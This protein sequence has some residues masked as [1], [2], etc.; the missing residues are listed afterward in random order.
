MNLTIFNDTH[1][2][3]TRQTGTTLESQQKL[4]Q[5]MFKQFSEL[6]NKAS[7]GDLLINGDIF[8]KAEVNKATEF[9]TYTLLLDWCQK[10]PE[11]T[12]YLAAGNHDLSKNSESVSSFDN[13]VAYLQSSVR[14]LCAIREHAFEIYEGVYV[15]PH[16]PNQE[17]FNQELETVKA[18]KPLY[19]FLHA[20][21]DNHFAAQTDH[22]LNVSEE[23][24]YSFAQLGCELV[25][26]HEHQKRELGN[27]HIIGNQ[28]ISSIS[29]CRG[30]T[31]KQYITLDNTG[32]HYHIFDQISERYAE[33]DWTANEIPDVDFIRITG[34]ADYENAAEVIAAFRKI[35]QQSDALIIT[36]AVNLKSLEQDFG[37]EIDDI[38]SYNVKQLILDQLPESLKPRFEE[39]DSITERQ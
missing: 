10:N 34:E 26:A 18:K 16:V 31:T 1:L 8:D 17:L 33:L 38:Q 2:G 32:L 19:V 11:Q 5:T 27:V 37:A 12:L 14:N 24:A 20:N 30:E 39:V 6:L 3:V 25:F 35:R 21:Y 4:S 29:D 7:G 22:S 9:K 13:L 23:M 28:I 15:I 36:N